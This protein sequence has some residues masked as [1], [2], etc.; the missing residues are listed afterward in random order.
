MNLNKQVVF[1]NVFKTIAPEPK[2]L[3]ESKGLVTNDYQNVLEKE[4]IDTLRNKY[5]F[6]INQDVLN[7]LK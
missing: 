4:W 1:V 2:S 6:T 7:T 3:N 5:K